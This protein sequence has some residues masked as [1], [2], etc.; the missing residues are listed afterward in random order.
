MST[1]Y[2][3][4]GKVYERIAT[5]INSKRDVEVGDIV[6][7]HDNKQPTWTVTKLERESSAFPEDFEAK[8]SK[9]SLGRG[10]ISPRQVTAVYRL[11]SE[12]LADSINIEGVEYEKV[13][14]S[15]ED[16]CDVLVGDVVETGEWGFWAVTDT[17]KNHS[18]FPDSFKA[19]MTGTDEGFGLIHP[20][21]VKAVY[22]NVSQIKQQPDQTEVKADQVVRKALEHME[23][24]AVTY[25]N[26]EGE[27]SIPSTVKAFN[28]ITGHTLSNEEGWLFM[29]LLKIVRSQQGEFKLDNYEDLS[30]YSGLM[31][32]DASKERQ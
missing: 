14:S 29:A 27:R 20:K 15:I 25:D 4:G 7:I 8:Q 9:G 2:R 31:A 28:I 11:K 23:D 26:E 5:S 30:A 21:E 13:T 24:R 16:K 12:S 18:F 3:E 17:E 32:E 10:L 19:V 1:E 6:S 22:R